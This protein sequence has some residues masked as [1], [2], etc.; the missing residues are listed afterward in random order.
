MKQ[1]AKP[2]PTSYARIVGAS[3]AS[4]DESVAFFW[5]D[6]RLWF[7]FAISCYEPLPTPLPPSIQVI[8]TF[9]LLDEKW[10]L[11]FGISLLLY[12]PSV[13]LHSLKPLN[14]FPFHIRRT[15]MISAPGV[16]QKM[17]DSLEGATLSRIG[18][19]EIRWN[20]NNVALVTGLPLESSY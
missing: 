2:V 18:G 17:L 15:R 4:D 11:E 20:V 13:Y 3:P 8:P 12:W 6:L 7:P 9:H 16:D 14:R 19:I 10:F 5:F 1:L